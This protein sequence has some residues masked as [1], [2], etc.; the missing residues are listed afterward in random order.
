MP[1]TNDAENRA[2]VKMRVSI[3]IFLLAISVCVCVCVCVCGQEHANERVFSRPC[4]LARKNAIV[5]VQMQFMKFPV[6]SNNKKRITS[7][8]N[9]IWQVTLKSLS[10]AISG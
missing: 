3:A 2:M 9:I 8:Y 5:Q 10:E 6:L 1:N 4:G 7:I